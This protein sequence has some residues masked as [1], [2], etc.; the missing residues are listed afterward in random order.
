MFCW[1]HYSKVITKIMCIG[2]TIDPNGTIL[3]DFIIML[4]G[5]IWRDMTVSGSD[6]LYCHT[7]NPAIVA[8]LDRKLFWT[9]QSSNWDI[10]VS[11]R[12]INSC[13]SFH[14]WHFNLGGNYIFIWMGSVKCCDSCMCFLIINA[15]SIASLISVST[16][17]CIVILCLLPTPWTVLD[18]F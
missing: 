10:F 4:G 11:G 1:W 7:L 12:W 15:W 8:I 14:A 18:H 6:F 2:M 9:Y 13:F 17:T 5:I 3:S 16:F